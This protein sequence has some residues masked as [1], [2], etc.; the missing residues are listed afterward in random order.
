MTHWEFLVSGEIVVVGHHFSCVISAA[1]YLF[2]R[3][4][5][6]LGP[7]WLHVIVLALSSNIG[8]DWII[9]ASVVQQSY[10]RCFV[11]DHGEQRQSNLILLFM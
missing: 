8:S 1:K 4:S 10:R 7:D 5:N 2:R 9:I 11:D 6:V 3:R